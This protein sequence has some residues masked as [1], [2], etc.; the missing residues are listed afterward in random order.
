M[1]DDST[2]QMNIRRVGLDSPEAQALIGA[3]NDELSRQYPDEDKTYFRLAADEVAAGNGAFLIA[4]RS[5]QAI[6]CG[7]VRRV[8]ERTGEI[9]R[10]YVR[11]EERGRRIGRAIV[12]ALEAEARALGITRLV[13]ETGIRQSAALSLYERAGFS[14][15]PAFGEYVGSPLSICMAKEL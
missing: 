10:M 9:K 13:L 5:G 11:P 4:F 3:L 2:D 14:R 7:A 6:A 12:A 15:T 1:A 8:D